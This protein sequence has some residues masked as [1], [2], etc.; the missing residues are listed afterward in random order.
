MAVAKKRG[1]G[2]P[3]GSTNKKR[4]PGRPKGSTN[5]RATKKRYD[6]VS[7]LIIG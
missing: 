1:P 2:R 6:N 3:K 4:G 7:V 5:K